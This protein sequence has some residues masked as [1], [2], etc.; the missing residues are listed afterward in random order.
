MHHVMQ[1]TVASLIA[2]LYWEGITSLSWPKRTAGGPATVW[3]RFATRR[4]GK[5]ACRSCC[6]EH[7]V[8]SLGEECPVRFGPQQI[9]WLRPRVAACARGL[10]TCVTACAS[11]FE[12]IHNTPLRG[13]QLVASGSDRR[14]SHCMT[15]ARRSAPLSSAL[16]MQSSLCVTLAMS[17]EMPKSPFACGG[18]G[19]GLCFEGG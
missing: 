17:T 3:D 8:G 14:P 2:A 1:P 6:W 16:K 12:C 7:R 15:R 4:L 18:F 13:L 10:C 5:S 11:F 9:R 19:L